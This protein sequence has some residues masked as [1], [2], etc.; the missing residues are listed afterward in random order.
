MRYLIAELKRRN[1]F[2]VAAAYAVVAWIVAQI[3]NIFFPA[4][5][6]PDWTV[7]F[8]IVLLILGFP[9]A[10]LLAWAYEITPD[11]VRREPL[12][13]GEAPVPDHTARKLNWA[14]IVLVVLAVGLFTGER[15]WMGERVLPEGAQVAEPPAETLARPDP[16]V[17]VLPFEN[18]SP[19]PDDAF[20]AGGMHGELIS[21]LSQIPDL[22]VISRTTML[23]YEDVRLP[24]QEIAGRLNVGTVMEAEVERI[25]DRVRVG[26]RLIDG[27][28]D[29]LIWSENY[30]GGFEDIH[31]IRAEV[32]EKV[33]VALRT[34]LSPGHAEALA[35]RPTDSAA[36]YEA[37]LKGLDVLG[38]DVRARLHDEALGGFQRAVELDPNFAEAWARLSQVHL[39]LYWFGEDPTESRLLKGREAAQRAYG[40]APGLP[41]VRFALANSHYRAREYHSALALI[42]G[43]LADTPDM[44][45]ATMVGGSIYRRQGR[46]EES[47]RLLER[48]VELDPDNP[49]MRWN[50]AV[51]YW[52][53]GRYEDAVSQ[54]EQA[55]SL[56]TDIEPDVYGSLGEIYLAWTGDVGAARAVA[57]R[58]PDQLAN[59]RALLLAWYEAIEGD[60]EA[61]LGRINRVPDEHFMPHL[62]P[63][64]GALIKGMLLDRLDRPEQARMQ[65]QSAVRIME[66]I[67]DAPGFD[68]RT[69]NPSQSILA[70][71]YA[72]LGRDEDA[73]RMAQR[74]R[75]ELPF[76]DDALRGPERVLWQAR[77]HA[78]L[79]N[80]TEAIET[81]AELVSMTSLWPAAWLPFDP[82][83]KPLHGDEGFERLLDADPR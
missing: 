66:S 36:A 26:I 22:R 74:S 61:A 37:Y 17:A 30:E 54:T 76:S 59:D 25:G 20:F 75:D 3:A 2:R 69:Q 83:L 62:S 28:A 12:A 31:A 46:W 79:D 82:L 81:L 49:A 64:P 58:L 5:H 53:L 55:L 11:G 71:A 6:L 23:A 35:V 18:L 68:P 29:A 72:G 8:V 14:V 38:R 9:V 70:F 65:Y 63:I 52:A 39:R 78:A 57:R 1:V 32:I 77:V 47:T 19:D 21:Q 50:L 56:Q 67:V 51:N 24:V 44:A 60:N 13:T 34:T 16:S 15:I 10:L 4:L 33:A 48:T 40:L 27:G 45:E 43:L 42:R 73:L 7:T 80:N 41:I